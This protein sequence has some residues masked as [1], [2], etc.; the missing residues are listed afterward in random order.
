MV[1]RGKSHQ[2]LGR[3]DSAFT[4]YASAYALTNDPLLQAAMGFCETKGNQHRDAIHCYQKAIAG[5][6]R[7]AIVHNDLGFSL[8]RVGESREALDNLDIAISLDPELQAAFVNRATIEFNLAQ[9]AKN[10]L[11]LKALQDISR[12]IELGPPSIEIYL[13]AALICA[14][15]AQT[16]TAYVAKGLDF[17]KQAMRHGCD[18]KLIDANPFF[19][20]F[21]KSASYKSLSTVTTRSLASPKAERI[22]SPL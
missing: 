19:S 22:V 3:F 1:L 15:A 8:F 14:L 12:A 21:R 17:L 16:D 2:A 10:Q 4:D 18:K 7:A 13:E 11:P 9:A 5:G 20:D 6:I